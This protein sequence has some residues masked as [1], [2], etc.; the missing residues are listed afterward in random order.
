MLF[1]F[2]ERSEP[3]VIAGVVAE[4]AYFRFLVLRGVRYAACI[5][6]SFILKFP[7]LDLDLGALRALAREKDSHKTIGETGVDITVSSVA[8][9]SQEVMQ[10]ES[11][12]EPVKK[13]SEKSQTHHF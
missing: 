5:S 2:L 11:G 10:R 8:Q 9:V 3:A 13:K 12:K 6:L 1:F 7:Q 4:G